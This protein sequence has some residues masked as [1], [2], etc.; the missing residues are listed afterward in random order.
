MAAPLLHPIGRLA[1]LTLLC[2]GVTAWVAAP[3]SAERHQVYLVSQYEGFNAFRGVFLRLINN[4][5]EGQPMSMDTLRLQLSVGNGNSWRTL[6]YDDWELGQTYRVEATLNQGLLTLE[7]NGKKVATSGR[8]AYTPSERRTVIAS[9]APSWYNTGEPPYLVLSESLT[10][11]HRGGELASMTW[12]DEQ[13]LPMRL[14]L[15]EPTAMKRVEVGESLRA[16]WKI[17]STFRLVAAPDLRDL[18]PFVDRYGQAVA[19]EFPGKVTSDED[20]HAADRR[21]IAWL[22]EHGVE[23]YDPFGGNKTLGW[24]EEATGFYRVV[25]RDGMWW[26]ISPQ[27]Y[28]TF[29]KGVCV[30]PGLNRPGTPITGREFLYEELP[31]RDGPFAPAW[32]TGEWGS[33]GID[34]VSFHAANMARKYGPEWVRKA[35]DRTAQRLNAWGFS[36]SGKWSTGG[37]AGSRV[38]SLERMA[39]VGHLRLGDVPRVGNRVDV[40]DPRARQRVEEVLREQLAPHVED[41]WVMG[42]SIGN[43]KHFMPHHADIVAMLAASPQ[44][45]VK[46]ALVTHARDVLYGGDAAALATAWGLPGAGAEDLLAASPDADTI[47]SEHLEALRA[48]F[49]D[50]YYAFFYRTVKTMAPNHLYFGSW[51]TPNWTV[52]D[53]EWEIH[54]R[55]CDV[56]GYDVYQF[57]FAPEHQ[58]E[59]FRSTDKPILL[60]EYGFPAFYD[61]S[62]GFGRFHTSATKDDVE[63]GAYYRSFMREAAENPWCVGMMWFLYRDQPITGRGARVVDQVDPDLV[64]GESH[65]FG[66]VDITDSPKWELIEAVR[67]ANLAADGIRAGVT[68]PRVSR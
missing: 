19:A 16:P 28:P 53:A 47:G 55:H 50:R 48:F 44:T 25:Q 24:R 9:S 27:G 36:G 45:P 11:R 57:T 43:E 18:A 1:A 37:E 67:E 63:S 39:Y 56:I 49:A 23:G 6:T 31:P 68:G 20:L 33:V 15:F 40:F 17:S 22:A 5:A 64:Y 14:R 29:F 51:N 52:S 54:G 10:M 61:G 8:V 7:V 58:L 3:A 34:F 21:E 46:R 12:P 59:L 62:R 35:T 38:S 26:M 2:V 4:P 42:W 66:L 41:P 32:F 60:G 30:V 65:A 13:T